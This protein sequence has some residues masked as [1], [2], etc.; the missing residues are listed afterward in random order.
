M[1]FFLSDRFRF[2]LIVGLAMTTAFAIAMSM[3]WPKPYWAGLAIG[4]CSMS[5]IGESVFKALQRLAG[6]MVAI[7]LSLIL[8]S[9]FAQDRWL[10]ALIVGLWM[11]FCTYKMQKTAM[12]YF[13]SCSAFMV[14]LLSMMSNFDS[15]TSF[16]TVE[17]RAKET[18]LG[19]LCYVVF[20]VLIARKPSHGAFR[21]AV[22]AQ[23]RLLRERLR[24]VRRHANLEPDDLDP[25]AGRAD[26]SRG[27]LQL[28]TM[29]IA[30]TLE[31]FDM[32]ERSRAWAHF[33]SNLTHF[34]LVLDRLDLS[35]E[36]LRGDERVAR[37]DELLA[38]LD[39][40]DARLKTIDDI[41][42][43][44][45]E[46]PALDPIPEM[47][48][49]GGVDLA[50][51]PF[52]AG[53]LLLRRERLRAL[54]ASSRRLYDWALDIADIRRLAPGPGPELIPD[55]F[56][57]DPE[58]LLRALTQF[59]T[60]WTTFLIYLVTPSLPDGPMIVIFG[61]SLGMNITRMPWVRPALLLRPFGQAILYGGVA[62]IF[63]LPRLDGFTQLAVLLFLGAFV[64]AYLFQP[65]RLQSMRFSGLSMF[66]M[67]LQIS[68]QSQTYNAI[69]VFNMAVAIC[70]LIIVLQII[71][72]TVVPWRPEAVVRRLFRRYADNLDA[73]LADMAWTRP[74]AYSWLSRQWR[75]HNMR[76]LGVLPV[77]IRDW[78]GRLD[79][80]AF[81]ESER[82]ALQN[83]NNRL[84]VLSHRVFDLARLRDSV[85]DP[86]FVNL[87]QDEI[88]G[89][90]RG[91][92]RLL[93]TLRDVDAS[94]DVAALG[95]KLDARIAGIEATLV[96]AASE[97]VLAQADPL[98]VAHMQQMLSAYRGVS[99][100]LIE[101]AA[102][103]RAP[104]WDRL[105]ETRF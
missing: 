45:G 12:F 95:A 55:S 78:I 66:V 32:R 57:P 105:A 75:R 98:H 84:A 91:I 59:A 20:A 22:R 81:S 68:N 18:T 62:H 102:R 94:V 82:E 31:S 11:T 3:G 76:Q 53:E 96:R 64:V 93:A 73:L 90:R 63:I 67:L 24:G 30:A 58:S 21:T 100:A 1:T 40:F 52:A 2:A 56:L 16:Y 38:A 8:I 23:V 35:F 50:Q 80:R 72:Q 33:L 92:R 9:L 60:F 34:S 42:G 41:L 25:F 17:E 36:A 26:I 29:R 48:R 103:A 77:D 47:P 15:Q 5:T 13:W 10:Y 89:W 43:S 99:T 6:T 28:P 44:A 74:R 14:P 65:E 4:V 51:D 69:Y 70:I 54:D 27:L 83:L 39:V 97:G 79:D 49:E 37:P 85:P 104:A 101:V 88:G 87:L 19:V 46:R 61:A 71:S 86:R 7:V